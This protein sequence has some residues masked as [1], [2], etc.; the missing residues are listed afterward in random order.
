M[1]NHAIF[2]V[3]LLLG[4]EAACVGASNP[5]PTSGAGASGGAS[6]G[7]GGSSP[8]TT[9]ASS[10]TG[11]TATAS[12][13]STTSST[14]SSGGGTNYSCTVK[15]T[16]VHECTLYLDPNAAELAT[17]M[18]DCAG[19]AGTSGTACSQTDAL[20]TC[21]SDYGDETWYSDGA[22]TAAEAQGSC[23]MSLGTW[24]PG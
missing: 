16:L 13:S 23:E 20:G 15:S 7:A 22:T 10:S 21:S 2:F 4:L 8:A 9:T 6:P 1:R 18:D 11:T 5:L 17:Y 12:S 19:L 24:T 14:S 3:S